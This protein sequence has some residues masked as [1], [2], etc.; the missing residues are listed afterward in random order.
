MRMRPWELAG[1]WGQ[2]FHGTNHGLVVSTGQSSAGRMPRDELAE[3]WAARLVVAYVIKLVI[4][5]VQGRQP[6]W[7]AQ[8]VGRHVRVRLHAGGGRGG[9]EVVKVSVLGAEGVRGCGVVR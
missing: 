7:P 8:R 9:R 2:R 1:S 6:L 4:C 3:R 5:V